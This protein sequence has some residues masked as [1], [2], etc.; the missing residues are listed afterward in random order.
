[1]KTELGEI[2]NLTEGNAHNMRNYAYVRYC[3]P[4]G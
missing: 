1:M 2:S 4:K 3:S